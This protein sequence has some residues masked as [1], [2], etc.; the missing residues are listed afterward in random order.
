MSLANHHSSAFRRISLHLAREAEHPNGDARD[1]YVL[2]APLQADGRIDQRL[3]RD[4]RDH[5]RVVHDDGEDTLVG[6]LMH[7]PGGRWS[8]RYDVSGESTDEEIFHFSDEQLRVGEYVSIIRERSAHP[9][10]V[11]AVMPL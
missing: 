7:G 11:V 10:R 6:H 2:V 9:F 4:H 3:W 5:C 1:R 8:I